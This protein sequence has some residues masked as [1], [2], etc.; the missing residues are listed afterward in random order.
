MPVGG[1]RWA[2]NRVQVSTVCSGA[3]VCLEEIDNG[4]REG[5]Y[6]WLMIGRFYER[7]DE[8]RMPIAGRIAVNCNLFLRAVL[9]PIPPTGRFFTTLHAVRFVSKCFR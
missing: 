2:F 9:L 7:R 1:I 4:I 8:L 3:Y 5:D 6:G